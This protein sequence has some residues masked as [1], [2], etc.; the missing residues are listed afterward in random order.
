M[1]GAISLIVETGRG[2]MPTNIVTKF[3]E[4]LIKIV[5][6][7]R[8]DIAVDAAER[9]HIIRPVFRRAYKNSTEL[10]FVPNALWVTASYM[11]VQL[12]DFVSCKLYTTQAKEDDSQCM[13]GL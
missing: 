12:K 3:E 13:Y 11:Y 2:I 8:A 1:P 9:V 6:L 4:D 5:W 7:K 10:L